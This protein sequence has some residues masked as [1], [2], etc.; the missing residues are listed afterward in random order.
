MNSCIGTTHILCQL[1]PA[2][3]LALGQILAFAVFV[4]GICSWSALY[5]CCLCLR[6]SLRSLWAC[7]FGQ[8]SWSTLCSCHLDFRVPLRSRGGGIAGFGEEGNLWLKKPTCRKHPYW[9]LE[10]LRQL[11]QG[12]GF[13]PSNK[14]LESVVTCCVCVCSL[15]SWSTLCSYSLVYI[16]T[17][18]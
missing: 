6:E 7:S 5:C 13:C 8:L 16:I 1:V 4:V 9:W 3:S 11:G 14:G 12:L 15:T 2:V 17:Y 18:C 10:K